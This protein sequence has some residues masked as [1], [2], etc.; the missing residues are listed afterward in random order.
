MVSGVEIRPVRHPE[1]LE[2]LESLFAACRLADGHDPLGEHK[3]LDLV[4]GGGE[5]TLG[6]VGEEGRQAVAYAHLTRNER[7]EVWGLEVAVHPLWRHTEIIERVVSAARDAAADEAPGEVHLWAYH[8]GIAETLRRLGFRQ[9]REL[10]QLRK[11][12]PAGEEPAYPPGVA[13]RAFRVGGDEQAWLEVNN[14]AFAGHPENGSWD[15]E[16]LRLRQRQDWFDPQGF[17]M[18]WQ[19]DELVGFCW[20][21]LHPGSVGEIYVIAV[22]PSHQG[23][24]LG[25]ALALDGLR[26]LSEERAARSAML[27]VDASNQAARRLYEHLGFHLDH[28]DQCFVAR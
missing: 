27:Y 21:K 22:A 24:G 12:L 20:T 9:E 7:A 17:L 25:K 18:A 5:S 15:L 8:P 16:T 28:V 23:A 13:V 3:Y 2:A 19:G 4:S 6:L 26:H 1:D 10:R 14:A 11:T